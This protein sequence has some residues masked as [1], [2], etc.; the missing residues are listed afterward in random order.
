ML[1]PSTP[2]AAPHAP[3][4]LTDADFQDLHL[5]VRARPAARRDFDQIPM[6][7][8]DL[9]RQVKQI[10]PAFAGQ[11]IAF[12]GDSD[13]MSA[14]LGLLS[15]RG[16]PRPAAL[17]LLDFDERLLAAF[18]A[19]AARHGFGDLL[20]AWRYNVFDPVPLALAGRYD[21][22]Y[23]NPPYGMRNNGASA[24]LFIARG[25][26]L[27]APGGAGGLVL[28]DDPARPWT[29]RAMRA[30]EQFLQ[31]HGWAVRDRFPAQHRYRLDDDPDL[32]SDLVIVEH[33]GGADAAALPY[34]GRRVAC[35]EILHFY[36]RSTP[37]P[38]PRYIVADGTLD[39]NW[40][41]SEEQAHEWQRPTPGKVA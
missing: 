15:A 18:R 10:A 25:C 30:T 22:F 23:T 41:M 33:I 2:A 32:T 20:R 5:V 35:A 34:A 19:L 38:Y 39:H 6:R 13:G 8:P 29:G 14:L 36:G 12:V 24:R 31:H 9:L 37:R 17:H 4:P 11:R 27:V 16:G 26:E 40:S 21:W 28:P 3:M 7:G 1:V